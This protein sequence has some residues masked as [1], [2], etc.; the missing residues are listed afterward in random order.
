MTQAPLIVTPDVWAE[1]DKLREAAAAD[2]LDMHKVTR[3]LESSAGR[4][5][6]RDRMNGQTVTI[7]GPWVF[8]VTYSVEVGHGCGP[9]RHMSMSI[10]RDGRVPHPEAIWMVAERMGF[11]GGL[12]ACMTW[13]EKLSDGGVAVNVI[14]P[15]NVSG[16]PQ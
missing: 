10:R 9:C 8:F 7:P 15:L 4:R 12:D 3:M 2:P 16:P 14:Q 13:P 11:S 1:L 6:P 5:A